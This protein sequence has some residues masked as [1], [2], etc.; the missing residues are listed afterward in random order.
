MPV[1]PA[2]M[3]KT[4]PCKQKGRY[5]TLCIK[6]DRQQ[7]PPGNSLY[8]YL[9]NLS[10]GHP[11]IDIGLLKCRIVPGGNIRHTWDLQYLGLEMMQV[12]E[13]NYDHPWIK[14][15]IQNRCKTLDEFKNCIE[16]LNKMELTVEGE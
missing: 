7:T 2:C 6:Y 8:H 10:I 3:P 9:F 1:M 4:Q 14:V 5:I 16:T 12:S 15:Y 13:K 11:C